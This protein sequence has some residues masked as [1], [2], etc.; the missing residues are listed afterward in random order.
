MRRRRRKRW[1]LKSSIFLFFLMSS[2]LVVLL[3]ASFLLGPPSLNRAQN[4]I[5]YST[6]GEV[7][8]EE[9]GSEKRYWVS[10]DSIDD[11]LEQATIMT[12][13]QHFYEHFGF[14]FKRLAGAIWKD[15]KTLSLKEGA[16]TITQQYA[17]NLYLTHEKTWERKL[18]EAF[19][20]V[21]L[22]MFYDKDELLE[23]Y[24]NT[25]YYGHGAYGIEAASKF[26]FDKPAAEL[27]WAEA[28]MLAG[29]PKGP[30]IYS[31]FHNSEKATERQR[32]ILSNL[33]DNGV[34]D[35]ATY[36]RALAEE[37][38]FSEQ[39]TITAKG[40]APYFQDV[41]LEE[42]QDLLDID[43]EE[44]RSGGYQVY[45]TL[46]LDQQQ[47]LQ[48]ARNSK[49]ENGEIE[50]GA[51]AMEP[52]DGAITALIGGQDYERSPFNRVTQAKRMPGS[53][54]KPFL[55]YAALENGMTAAS[56]LMS[57]PT[58]FKLENGNT[59]QPS[60]Y[61]D[62]YADKPI[63]MAQALALSDN[64]FAVKTNLY[65]TPSRLVRMLKS[66]F[67]FT[68][69]I[70]PVASLALGSE[71][72]TMKEMVTGYA[73][74]ANGG[75][76]IEPYTI[77]QVTD[78]HG[79]ILY[80][81][82]EEQ[83]D[84]SWSFFSKEEDQQVLNQNNAYILSEMMKGMFKE[85]LNGYMSVTGASIAPE[86]S[87]EYAGK[88]G[89]T[90]SDNW[91]LGFSPA[92]VAGVWTGYDDNREIVRTADKQY[93][94]EVWAAFME[95]AHADLPFEKAVKPNDVMEV[96]IDLETGYIASDDCPNA[97]PMYFVKGTQPKQ[98]CTIHLDGETE[99]ETGDDL[100]EEN[101][102][103]GDWWDW[104]WIGEDKEQQEVE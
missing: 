63:T 26:F 75:K 31:P 52:D 18:Y 41:V 4:T 46:N 78:A 59:Y 33:Y 35:D 40:V 38:D 8:G 24:L 7:I 16:S 51:M 57:Q 50:I 19:Y 81:R 34:I 83:E 6:D 29:I 91:M 49:V 96:M 27:S 55:Y 73:M 82:Q 54:F 32:L 28:A 70:E 56:T 99:T 12:E 94:K 10:L 39:R 66:V 48:Q 42:L 60:N 47:A 45:T 61:N 98:H 84:T 80:D 87:Y 1:I 97:Y 25:I 77:K 86:L 17:R 65:V 23:G 101:G 44:I 36:E 74:I 64:I 88:S 69:E 67:Q 93:A 89:T 43:L 85:E 79:T 2:F 103:I 20:T 71:V 15:I 102:L 11:R 3:I 30:S 22:E 58:T 62:Y 100:P 21:R 14:D 76:K 90:D 37:L 92:L 68:S 5:Y 53:A 9:F 13:D 95:E 72:V 104:L